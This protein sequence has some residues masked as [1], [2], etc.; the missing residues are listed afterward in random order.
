MII[1]I[2]AENIVFRDLRHPRHAAL[3]AGAEY[4]LSQESQTREGPVTF[5]VGGA[6]PAWQGTS[7]PQVLGGIKT[8]TGNNTLRA[9]PARRRRVHGRG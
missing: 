1:A 2:E 3:S 9:L 5:A 7:S 4:E 6:F 8:I